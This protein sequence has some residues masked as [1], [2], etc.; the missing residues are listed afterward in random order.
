MTT[1]L[2]PWLRWLLL[3]PW[4]V[5]SVAIGAISY[6]VVGRGFGIVALVSSV[7]LAVLGLWDFAMSTLALVMGW[8]FKAWASELAIGRPEP[9][10][11]P[12]ASPGGKLTI[13]M[14]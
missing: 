11:K 14:R 8:K 10:L 2:T 9:P 13:R 7:V 3:V 6:K 1:M 4:W 5:S 12:L